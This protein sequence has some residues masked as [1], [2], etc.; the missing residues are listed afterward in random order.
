MTGSRLAVFA[1]GAAAGVYGSFRARRMAYRLTPPGLADQ[2]NALLA[3]A[4][5]FGAEVRVGMAQRERQLA[6]DL[7]LH[8]I[9]DEPAPLDQNAHPDK[10][11]KEYR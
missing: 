9:I 8:R 2:A 10:T 1:A 5:E 7:D 11:D 6:H 3:G 4:R